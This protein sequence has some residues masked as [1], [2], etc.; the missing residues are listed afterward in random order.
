M[1]NFNILAHITFQINEGRL[2]RNRDHGLNI[3]YTNPKL[4]S[5]SHFYPVRIARL[6]NALPLALRITLTQPNSIAVLKLKLNKF[7]MDK[8]VSTFESDNMCTWVTACR[9]TNCRPWLF[10]P[11]SS[12]TPSS[13]QP[14]PAWYSWPLSYTPAPWRQS[15][16]SKKSRGRHLPSVVRQLIAAPENLYI[17]KCL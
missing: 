4:E 6:W 15:I 3:N 7:Y 2:T 17:T 9:C 1:I 11:K 16:N 12:H 10:Q 8:L 5:S 14:N 13:S